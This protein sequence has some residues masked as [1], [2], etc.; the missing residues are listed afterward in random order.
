VTAARYSGMRRCL[1]V[2]I[3]LALALAGTATV[4]ASIWLGVRSFSIHERHAY[5]SANNYTALIISKQGRFDLL[6]V[7]PW[8]A[9]EPGWLHFSRPVDNSVGGTDY[10]HRVL[11]FG[12]GV[13]LNGGIF[14]NVPYWLTGVI[15]AVPPLL[16]A[17]N[18]L[19]RRRKRHGA[20]LVCGYDLRATPDRC[21]ECGTSPASSV[22]AA[23]LT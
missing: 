11:G 22:R 16:L 10:S 9:D 13:Q 4:I 18:E 15:G 7:S 8:T 14:V 1:G 6:Y 19:R 3:A 5:E 21:P 12:G 20:C 2:L 23:S 17:R